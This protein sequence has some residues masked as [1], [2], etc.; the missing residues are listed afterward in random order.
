M[1]IRNMKFY[2]VCLFYVCFKESR[3]KQ[4]MLNFDKFFQ[5]KKMLILFVITPSKL[6]YET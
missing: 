4:T 1:K 2:N 5:M 3:K 6:I